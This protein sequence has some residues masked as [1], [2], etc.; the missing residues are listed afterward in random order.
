MKTAV[1]YARYSSDRQT[2]QSIEGQLRDCNEYAERN[3]IIVL[4][5]YIDRAMTGTNDKRNEF[6]RMLKD[7]N[8]RAWDYVLVYKTDRFG[9]NKYELAMNKH[10]L[11]VNGIRLIPVKENIPDGPEGIIL[12]SLL[13]GMAEYY[14]AELSQKV[15][16]GM[17]ES[18][19]KGNYTGGFVLFG[20]RVENKK[21]VIHEDEAV[22]VRQM[23]EDCA[24]GKLVKT[25]IDELREKGILYRGKPFARNTVYHLL[26]NEKYAGIY[27]H[28]D[29]IFT[30]IYPRIVPDEIFS[31]VASKIANNKYGK[32]KPNIYYLLRNKMICGYC[33]KPVNS[34]S[35]TSKNG[36][37]KRYYKC[38]GKRLDKSCP[39]NSIRKDLIEKIVLDATYEALSTK[40]NLTLLANKVIEAH[41]KRVADESLR[42]ILTSEYSETEK[43][44]NNILSAMEQ[45]VIT[46]STKERLEHLEEKKV[47]LLAKIAVERARTKLLITQDDIT[48][49]ISTALRKEPRPMVDALIKK[50]VLYNDKI[51][52][53]YNYTNMKDPDG[54]D[55]H[56][57]FVFYICNKS[58]EIDTHKYERAP[59]L[60]TF[61]IE[62]Y[63]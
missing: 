20:Y 9:R 7:S 18:R 40:E 49:F 19:S 4:D 1:I 31:V 21:L 26:A 10:T 52:I 48:K 50:V 24:S 41:K 13:E 45:G 37:I 3:D 57:D 59:I 32:H 56:R 15:K 55:S 46:N 12:E 30:N 47:D 25:I 28:G 61:S 44:I 60:L 33:G 11:K 36:E 6:Q 34:D 14:S 27:R 23:F 22:I 58:F 16:R 35:G 43:A 38:S 51:E 17:R 53:Y 54:T 8:K 62:L 39:C 63:A 5:T 2:E 42:H 29:E